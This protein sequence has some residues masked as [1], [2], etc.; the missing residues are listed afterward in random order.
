MPGIPLYISRDLPADWLTALEFGRVS[1]GLTDGYFRYVGEDF[2]WVRADPDGR[3]V[4]FEVVDL[5]E[6]D[7][8]AHTALW[9]G[10]RFN[11]PLFG[12][13]RATAGEV[14]LAARASLDEES[15][16]NRIYFR[17]AINSEGDDALHMWR[18][19]LETGDAMAHFAAGY[20][21]YELERPREAYAHLRHYTEIA[22]TNG[23]AWSWR[24]K[25]CLALGE[26]EE[27]RRAF[28]R[29]LEL[30]EEGGME[31]DAAEHLEEDFGGEGVAR[32][33]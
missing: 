8:E 29:A 16:M 19:C 14:L 2:R 27:A 30:E 11:V 1:D 32:G 25:A 22:P 9:R 4:G 10:P 21:L 7:A 24:G 33:S 31:T 26:R 28:E 20:T 12:L 15:T 17:Q 23:W 5:T 6:F 13:L 18:A 3:T